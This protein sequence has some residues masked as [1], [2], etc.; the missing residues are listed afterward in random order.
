MFVDPRFAGMRILLAEDNDINALLA[1]TMIR[2]FGCVC[3]RVSD[4]AA[5]VEAVRG[6]LE[7]GAMPYDLVMMDLAMPEI[8]GISA[9]RKIRKLCAD[10]SA[11]FP[12][13]VAVTANAFAEDRA[14]ALSQGMDDYL[15]KPFEKE[16]LVALLTACLV[17][18]A[19]ESVRAG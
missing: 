6:A 5:A 7:L 12:R 1:E 17:A 11:S 4:G 19:G 18:P 16:Q 8:D 15:S 2:K 14:E 13:I 10:A 9:M 3:D